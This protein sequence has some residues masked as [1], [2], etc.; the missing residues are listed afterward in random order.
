MMKRLN[1]EGPRILGGFPHPP[2]ADVQR[3]SRELAD[4]GFVVDTRRAADFGTGHVPGTIN[5]PMNSS[6]TTWAGWL[7]PFDRDVYLIVDGHGDQ[8]ARAAAPPP[9]IWR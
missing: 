4:G 1:K 6:F 3:L 2:L 8:A 9:A 7:V 5:I